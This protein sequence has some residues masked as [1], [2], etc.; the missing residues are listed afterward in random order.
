MNKQLS[1]AIIIVAAIGA[2]N[3][4][5][6]GAFNLDLVAATFGYMSI[7]TRIVYIIVGLAG[8]GLLVGIKGLVA[9]YSKETKC[10]DGNKASNKEQVPIHHNVEPKQVIV[11][12]SPAKPEQEKFI[13]EGGNSQPI[14][15]IP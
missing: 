5:L 15:K 2:I 12:E 13:D 7:L 9:C 11:P 4:G 10:G 8:I 14:N 3:W 1:L 6:V